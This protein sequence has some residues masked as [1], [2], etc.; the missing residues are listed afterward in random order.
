MDGK[1]RR[2]GKDTGSWSRN[3]F[4]SYL[5]TKSCREA[6]QKRL[7]ACNCNLRL[8]VYFITPNVCQLRYLLSESLND[9]L[10]IIDYLI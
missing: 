5:I 1:L 2:T 8:D 9:T 3:K 10:I 7:F 6:A 4:V